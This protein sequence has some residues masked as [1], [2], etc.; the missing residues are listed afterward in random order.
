MAQSGLQSGVLFN[1]VRLV[2]SASPDSVCTLLD[3]TPPNHRLRFTTS[4][5]ATLRF[6]H[7][8]YQVLH[9]STANLAVSV[10]KSLLLIRRLVG[11]SALRVPD[12]GLD[13]SFCRWVGSNKRS[14]F[15]LTP[16][17]FRSARGGEAHPDGAHALRQRE[18]VLV[19]V[20]G[21]VAVPRL[22]IAAVVNV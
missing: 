10:N 5:Y 14:A 18:Q 2:E 3:P 9:D 16:A 21:G 4:P 13:C 22:R 20:P 6:P 19:P 12:L 8:T 1:L 17:C 15:S 11:N 7:P